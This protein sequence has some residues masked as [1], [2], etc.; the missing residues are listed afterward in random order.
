MSGSTH[1]PAL[2]SNDTPEFWIA[3]TDKPYMKQFPRLSFVLG[4]CLVLAKSV[5][6]AAD[7]ATPKGMPPQEVLAKLEA[8]NRRF[9]ENKTRGEHRDADRR[10][11]LASG[12]KPEAII[13]SCSDSRVP[14]ELVFDQGLGDLF[15][16]RVAGNVLGAA[17]VASIEYAVEHLG[18]R[19]IVVLG[20]ESC[21]A[22]K[23]AL[24]TPVGTSIG[25]PDLD[26]LVSTIQPTLE[27]TDRKIAAQDTLL[28]APVMAN[29]SF[30]AKRLVTRSPII[31]KHVESGN[32]KIVTGI[33]GLESGKVDFTP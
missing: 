9:V 25:S 10:R 32:L 5:V 33:Y 19:L 29:A 16:I 3:A 20:H 15:T 11:A 23:A 7:H 12:Q 1:P 30:V 4:L 31:R 21:G 14:P 17:T 6:F 8:G 26:Q 18:S 13:L 24:S 28:R 2:P 22:V 27:G